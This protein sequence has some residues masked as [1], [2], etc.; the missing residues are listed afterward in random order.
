MTDRT[1]QQTQ[2]WLVRITPRTPTPAEIAASYGEDVAAMI[3]LPDDF[4]PDLIGM[5]ARI[6]AHYAAQ[7]L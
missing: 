7:A 3:G 6:A 4:D 2:D 1:P 5:Y